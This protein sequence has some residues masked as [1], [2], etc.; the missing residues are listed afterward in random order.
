MW[1]RLRKKAPVVLLTILLAQAASTMGFDALPVS[2]A[3]PAGGGRKYLLAIGI[4][5]YPSTP[6]HGCVNDATGIFSLLT[7]DFGF[8]ASSSILLREGEA[9]RAGIISSVER[10]IRL[11]GRGDLFVFFYSGHGSLFPDEFSEVQDETTTLNL[12]YLR[13]STNG[14]DWP[15]GRYDSALVP[16]DA[17]T[18]NSGKRWRGLILDD[19]LFDLF[20]RMTAKGV[21]VILISDSCHSGTLA[22]STDMVGAPKMIDPETAIGLKMANIAKPSR[23]ETRSARDLSGLYLALTSSQ[24]NQISFDGRY[25]DRAQGL[26]TYAFVKAILGIPPAQRKRVTYTEIHQRCRSLVEQISGNQQSPQIDRRYYSGE[27]NQPA[28]SLPGLVEAVHGAP[29][30]PPA[31]DGLHLRITVTGGD[32]AALRGSSFALFK[33]GMTAVPATITPA[34]TLAI[35]RT[36]AD[37]E[38]VSRDPVVTPGEYLIKVV[39]TG[40]RTLIRRV[41]L[42]EDARERGVVRLLIK[43]DPE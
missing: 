25:E 24:D 18:A 21:N 17:A 22:R 10:F 33:R 29:A 23:P 30:P 1:E 6:L 13:A 39:C 8:E 34:D 41:R 42:Y 43:L 15:D 12:G 38:A 27:L 32:G 40:Y 37:G 14:F 35:L 3:R 31:T 26:F 2:M 9:T 5:S 16:I 28:F 20:S 4:N 11:T 7:G 19:E 36:G